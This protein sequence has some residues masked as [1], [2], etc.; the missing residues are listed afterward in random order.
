MKALFLILLSC[1]YNG[2]NEIIIIIIRYNYKVIIHIYL[3]PAIEMHTCQFVI[4]GLSKE[5]VE[6]LALVDE[7]SSVSSHINECLLRD[8]PDCLVQWL[9]II[10]NLLHVLWN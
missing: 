1:Y 10:W 8:F 9:E 5:N 3:F 7:G 4:V 6:G 2:S